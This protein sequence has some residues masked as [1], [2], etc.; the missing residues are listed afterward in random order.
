MFEFIAAHLQGIQAIFLEEN[1]VNNKTMQYACLR[2]IYMLIAN[3]Y[4][5]LIFVSR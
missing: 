4:L 3:G 5:V 2:F 1:K